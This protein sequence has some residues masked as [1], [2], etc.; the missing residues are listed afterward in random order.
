MKF[1]GRLINKEQPTFI[2]KKG[3]KLKTGRYYKIKFV[4]NERN[5]ELTGYLQNFDNEFYCFKFVQK[6]MG[7]FK[8]KYKN[9]Y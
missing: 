9:D 8:L 7:A 4:D 6:V 2:I 1:T 5:E 3:G